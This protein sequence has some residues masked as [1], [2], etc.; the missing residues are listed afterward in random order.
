MESIG[1]LLATTLWN[2]AY[3][4]TLRFGL[5]E[6][7]LDVSIERPRVCQPKEVVSLKVTPTRSVATKQVIQ[8]DPNPALINTSFGE[9]QNLTIADEHEADHATNERLQQEV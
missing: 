7:A 8:C 2:L 1:P 6:Y 4:G 5:N 9:R 3:T